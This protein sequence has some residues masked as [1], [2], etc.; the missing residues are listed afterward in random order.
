VRVVQQL[1]DLGQFLLTAKQR[2][3]WDRQR[4]M[5]AA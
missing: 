2:G 4:R 5:D 3:G 1:A